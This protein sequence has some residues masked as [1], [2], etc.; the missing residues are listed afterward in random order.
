MRRPRW[1]R[2]T[3]RPIGRALLLGLAVSAGVTGLSRIGTLAGWEA[4]AVDTFLFF[5]ERVAS[6]TLVIV[7]IDDETF[8]AL[9]ERQPLD[10]RFLADLVDFLFRSGARTVALD[11]QLAVATQGAADAALVAATR[12]WPAG[13]LAFAAPVTA[14]ARV[15]GAGYDFAS[16]FS[17]ALRAVPGFPNAPQGADGV[18]RRMVPVLPA[19]DGGRF[20]P[21][22]A[23]TA[24]A[25]AAGYSPDGLDAALR[26]GPRATLT[27]PVVDA[28]GRLRAGEPI[29]VATLAGPPWRVDFTGPPNS[30][31]A[32]PAG[33]LVALA[34][35][36]AQPAADNPFAGR[37]VLVGSTFADS[38]DFYPTPVGR[39]AG[40]EIQANML[41]TLLA[42]RALLPPH[43]LLNLALLAG[44]CV[45]TALLALWLRPLW[46]A[47][48]AVPV[49][50]AIV[51]L[52]YEAYTRG[53]WLDFVAPVLA[54][55]AALQSSA[56]LARRRLRA[57]F[58][59]YVSPEVLDRVLREG[60]DLAGE[61]RTVTVLMSDV[62]GFT[63]LSERLPPA[64]ITEIMNEYFTVM[65]EVVLAHRGTVS[66]FIGD[67]LMVVFGAPLD[68]REHAAHAV[69]TALG[70]QRALADLNARWQ[71][72]GAPT[73]AIGVAINTGEVFAGTMGSPRKKKYAVVGDPVNA[74]AR[75]EG[76]NRELGTAI[77]ISGTTRAAV[78]DRVR[79]RDRGR[80]QVKGRT[81]AI[82]IFEL[83]AEGE[84]PAENGGGA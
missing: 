81:Q 35:S 83:L 66:D 56:T 49:I 23:L 39:M 84:A 82:E 16:P 24:L 21:S 31:T 11:V 59:Q 42:R 76:L 38:R 67:G 75:I 63:T 50:L 48:A 55:L 33:P 26:A 45:A 54:M 3:A 64:A 5:R 25:G 74:T 58:G 32:F 12:R 77:L 37:L 40:V 30:I 28:A 65:V 15:G 51:V 9:G 69:A 20:L 72:R 78:G 27:L 47:L 79:V 68:D 22:L 14:R 43:P 53:Y 57:A 17:R 41:H 34:R 71:A 46:A 36:G 61:L 8:R 10:R 1:L 2:R 6:P 4:R 7:A 52:S 44:V 60:T 80:V 29:A 73:L 13:R 62:R 19:A 70:M 18:I